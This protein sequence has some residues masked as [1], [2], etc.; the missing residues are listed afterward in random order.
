[1]AAVITEGARARRGGSKGKDKEK[2]G[3]RGEPV[4]SLVENE[5]RVRIEEGG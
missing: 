2:Y 1:M 5:C 4:E 3:E